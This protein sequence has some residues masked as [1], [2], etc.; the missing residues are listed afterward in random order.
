VPVD[1]VQPELERLF[2]GVTTVAPI[3]PP[4]GTEAL[5]IPRALLRATALIYRCEIAEVRAALKRIEAGDSIQDELARCDR[6]EA[7]VAEVL[8]QAERSWD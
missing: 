7:K 8:S 6:L 4:A 5:S 1:E 2:W 3:Q